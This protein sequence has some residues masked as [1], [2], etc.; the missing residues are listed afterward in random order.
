MVKVFATLK[1]R[2][3][4]CERF[5]KR[6]GWTCNRDPSVYKSVSIY[7]NPSSD[8]P[9]QY[10]STSKTMST[11]IGPDA[12][13]IPWVV[14]PPVPAHSDPVWFWWLSVDYEANRRWIMNNNK[15]LNYIWI[16]I[17]HEHL[18]IIIQ[19]LFAAR[20]WHL[21]AYDSDALFNPL[22]TKLIMLYCLYTYRSQKRSQ[23]NFR[24]NTWESEGFF[25]TTSR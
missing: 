2:H 11:A 25:Y 12:T 16:M 9:W 15:I 23:H 6:L 3:F 8:I 20:W 24:P 1:N 5:A 21:K 7:R 19:I 10:R 4:R 22:I 18:I 14:M 13:S 17:N